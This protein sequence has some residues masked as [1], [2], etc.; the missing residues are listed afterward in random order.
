MANYAK[1]TNFTTKDSLTSGN[2][3]KVIKGAEIDAEFDA[4]FIAF[5]IFL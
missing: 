5:S 1:A 2:A 3:L 4:I